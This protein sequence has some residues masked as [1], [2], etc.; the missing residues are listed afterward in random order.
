MALRKL[1]YDGDDILRKKAKPVVD[2]GKKLRELTEDMIETMNHYSGIGLAAPQIG[3]MRRVMVV[4]VGEGPVVFVNPEIIE[5]SGEQ[6]RSEG[7]LSIPGKT[8]N[9]TRPAMTKIRAWDIN[10]EKFEITG[11]E[12]LSVAINHELDHLNGILYIDKASEVYDNEEE[13]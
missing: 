3:V 8:G 1:R 13:L 12:L 10:G 2:F 9:V 4:D 11:E 6:E 5:I 7:C